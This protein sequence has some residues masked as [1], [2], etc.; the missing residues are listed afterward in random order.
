MEKSGFVFDPLDYPDYM[1]LEQQKA[2]VE[3]LGFSVSEDVMDEM[4]ESMR[5]NE[6]ARIYIEGYPFQ[7]LL[8][9][10]GRPEHGKDTRD[11]ASSP[12][13]AYWLDWEGDD[14]PQDYL[15]LLKGIEN[16]THGEMVLED[17]QVNTNNAD[18]EKGSGEIVLDFFC[19]GNPY[20]VVLEVMADW[21]DTSVIG[22]MNRILCLERLPGRIYACSDG[23]QGAVL[24]YRDEAWA[25]QF[26]KETKLEL[27]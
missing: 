10:L 4:K 25:E 9:Y 3:A 1:P 20:E 27:E 15:H 14:I 22:Q 16:L 2:I 7:E 21:L 13:Q 19:N 11:L 24:F 26:K 17:V 8:L 5:K 12:K 23:G 18:W 6:E